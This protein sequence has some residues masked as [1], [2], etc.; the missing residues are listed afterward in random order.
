MQESVLA[1]IREDY[2]EQLS[3]SERK[4]NDDSLKPLKCN[5][6]GEWVSS[7][8]A[9]CGKCGEEVSDNLHYH[10]SSMPGEDIEEGKKR[11]LQEAIEEYVDEE[12]LLDKLGG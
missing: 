2:G 7:L 8:Q 1:G 6:C 10:N 9:N 5:G 12:G 3:Q 11:E 4:F